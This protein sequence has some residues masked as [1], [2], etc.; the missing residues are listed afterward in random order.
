MPAAAALGPVR[1]NPQTRAEDSLITRLEVHAFV[2]VAV[3]ACAG[4][5]EDGTCLS[6]SPFEAVHRSEGYERVLSL[7]MME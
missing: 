4:M 5:D 2:G 3:V 1:T 7:R 6:S